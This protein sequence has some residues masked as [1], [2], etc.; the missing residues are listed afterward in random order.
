M[1]TE[2]SEVT[3]VFLGLVANLVSTLCLHFNL[4]FS[5]DKKGRKKN[6]PKNLHNAFQLQTLQ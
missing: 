1:K 3:E 5:S 4:K 2:L 6:K